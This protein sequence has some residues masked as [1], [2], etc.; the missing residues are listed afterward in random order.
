MAAMLEL[1]QTGRVKI[2]LGS[3]HWAQ[4]CQPQPPLFL[5]GQCVAPWVE[6]SKPR[7]PLHRGMEHRSTESASQNLPSCRSMAGAHDLP[8]LGG[9]LNRF[10]HICRVLT[11]C[12]GD[13]RLPE[14]RGLPHWPLPGSG[15]ALN[16]CS[17]VYHW[18]TFRQDLRSSMACPRCTTFAPQTVLD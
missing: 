16:S 7:I 1:I 6:S 4:I 13:G 5:S 14:V 9:D 18:S 8:W 2:R 15:C 12:R 17:L 3:S 10:P 11:C